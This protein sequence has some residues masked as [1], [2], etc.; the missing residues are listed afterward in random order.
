MYTALNNNVKI[1]IVGLGTFKAKNG[2]ETYNAV[3]KAIEVGYR[4]IDTASIYGN[5]DSVGKAIK[6]SKIDRKDI[7]VT[8]KV[9]NSEQGYGSTKKAFF[10]S[11]EKLQ[12]DYIDLYLVHWPTNYELVRS[13]YRAMEELYK[14]NRIRAIGVSNFNIHHIDDLLKTCEV[15]P[16]INQVELHP[17]LQ[18]HKLQNYCLEKGIQITSHS[19]MMRGRAFEIKELKLLAKKYNKNIVNIIVRWGIQRNIIMIPKSVTPQRIEDNF[20]VFDFQLDEEDM[21]IIRRINNAKRIS[22]DPDNIDF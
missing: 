2:E 1:P 5:E 10:E 11:L 16:A 9:W 17:G 15:K 18:Q 3:R 21:K 7:F 19:P 12:L 6:D 20:K 8:T 22:S 14:E 13:T 4:H